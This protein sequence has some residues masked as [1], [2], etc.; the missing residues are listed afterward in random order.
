MARFQAGTS[1]LES[2]AVSRV[3][4]AETDVSGIVSVSGE[5]SVAMISVVSSLCATSAGLPGNCSA[6]S[7][8]GSGP[9][10]SFCTLA[11]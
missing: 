1:S 3:L 4:S 7:M 9:T 8:G 10:S 11:S 6:S 5:S 2:S